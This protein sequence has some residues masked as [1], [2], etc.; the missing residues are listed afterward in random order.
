MLTSFDVHYNNTVV[1]TLV[2]SLDTRAINMQNCIFYIKHENRTA[3][4][5]KE[6]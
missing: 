3:F 4:L 2:S 5:G 6:L 1:Y